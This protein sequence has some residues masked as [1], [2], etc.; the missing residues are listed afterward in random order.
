MDILARACQPDNVSE[1]NH[2]EKFKTIIEVCKE[3]G[4]KFSG[5]CSANVDM[6]IN[7]LYKE[8]KIS[9]DGSYKERNIYCVNAEQKSNGR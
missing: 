3:N 5:L 1:A 9:T 4:V 7:I 6:A 2:C 8:G